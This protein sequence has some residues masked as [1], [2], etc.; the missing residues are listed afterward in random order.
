MKSISPRIIQLYQDLYE[1]TF[2]D[3]QKVCD[4]QDCCDTV[5]CLATENYAREQYGVILERTEHATLP[6]MGSHGC[7]V[8][9]HL[10]PICTEFSCRR[11]AYGGKPG[12]DEWAEKYYELRRQILFTRMKEERE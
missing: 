7:T 6:F 9:P 11:L 2:N 1:H 3:C 12:I 10:R 5:A 8:P 4:R